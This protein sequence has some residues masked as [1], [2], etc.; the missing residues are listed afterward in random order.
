MV[1]VESHSL[2]LL[3]RGSGGPLTPYTGGGACNSLERKQDQDCAVTLEYSGRKKYH[4]CSKK[5]LFSDPVTLALPEANCVGGM[6]GGGYPW[7]EGL[8]A[9]LPRPPPTESVRG[10]N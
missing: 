1:K 9:A 2:T 3:V 4:Q 10:S 8:F 7:E 5:S 6:R